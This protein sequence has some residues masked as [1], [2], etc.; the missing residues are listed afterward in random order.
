MCV[1]FLFYMCLFCMYDIQ[2]FHRTESYCICGIFDGHF[3]LANLSSSTKLNVH[4]VYTRLYPYMMWIALVSKLNTRQFTSHTNSPNFMSTKYTVYVFK[5][6]G[7]HKIPDRHVIF[8]QR[9]FYCSLHTVTW[10]DN[11][12]L[13]IALFYLHENHKDVQVL[14]SQSMMSSL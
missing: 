1:S 2:C 8:H 5:F 11:K 10:H 9:F 4:T 13:V 14:P 12:I 6:T 3:N 7:Y